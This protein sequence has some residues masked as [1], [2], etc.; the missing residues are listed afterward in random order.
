MNRR[1]ESPELQRYGELMH[2]HEKP[3]GRVGK[4]VL[5]GQPCKIGESNFG[6]GESNFL[7]YRLALACSA[8][9]CAASA[10]FAEISAVCAAVP[11][12]GVSL[13][14]PQARGR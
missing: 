7:G 6:N 4:I 5:A 14:S 1:P 2:L 11:Q 9:L 13:P 8:E 10:S 3:K 12:L